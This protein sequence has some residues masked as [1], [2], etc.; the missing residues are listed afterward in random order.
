MSL[1]YSASSTRRSIFWALLFVAVLA[2]AVCLVLGLLGATAPWLTVL[3]LCIGV[4]ATTLLCVWCAVY[5]RE[6][7][8]LVRIALIWG[9]VLFLLLTVAVLGAAIVPPRLD[10]N[11]KQMRVKADIQSI[12][13]MLLS[14]HNANGHYPSTD[15]GLNALVPKLMEELPKD[16][17]GTP[18]V[19]RCPG[20]VNPRSHDLFSAGPDRMPD[21]PDDD[22]GSSYSR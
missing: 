20:R 21:T 13:T 18:Y 1:P 3:S 6:E 14:Y 15:Q 22:W 4:A 7:P 19:Y 16:S 2:P 9:A 11:M 17:W 12:R 8:G 5:V 10:N